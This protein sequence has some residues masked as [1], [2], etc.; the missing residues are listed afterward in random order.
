MIVDWD[1]GFRQAWNDRS[2]IYRENSY[3]MEWCVGEEHRD[4]A[5]LLAHSAG[6]FENLP[7]MEG[8]IT[9]LQEMES[10]GFKV[11]IVTAPILTSFHCV[12]EKVNWVRK[13]LG[14]KWLD[15]LVLC[16]DKVSKIIFLTCLK[17]FFF[18]AS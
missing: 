15:K 1:A 17:A 12:Q 5:L 14:E 4:E 10:E 16:T 18:R 7:P 8:A 13:H 9:A 6:F 2:P 11:Y 3:Y